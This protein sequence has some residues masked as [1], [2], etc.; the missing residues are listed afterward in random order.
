MA[1]TVVLS[2]PGQTAQGALD[3]KLP[4]WSYLPTVWVAT[5]MFLSAASWPMVFESQYPYAGL[6]IL[7]SSE[8]GWPLALATGGLALFLLIPFIPMRARL[9]IGIG[10]SSC[11]A[12][13]TAIFVSVSAFAFCMLIVY[14][15][16][17]A[18]EGV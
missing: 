10:F 17:N 18:V 4:R 5:L 8:V 16:V 2:A 7:G 12:F 11:L 6:R 14:A 15:L 13:V 9:L 1:N 3:L